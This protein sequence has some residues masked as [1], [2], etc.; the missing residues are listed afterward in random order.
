M[1]RRQKGKGHKR[2]RSW[3]RRGVGPDRAWA[4]AVKQLDKA[5]KNSTA[6]REE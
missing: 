3:H 1:G 2:K 6:N 4:R 5:T